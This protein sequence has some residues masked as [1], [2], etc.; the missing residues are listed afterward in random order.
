MSHFYGSLHL[1]KPVW[2]LVL[3]P[4][5]LRNASISRA[6]DK[7][8]GYK[9]HTCKPLT[10]WK[11]YSC[12]TP[13]HT[14]CGCDFRMFLNTARLLIQHNLTATEGRMKRQD[15]FTDLHSFSTVDWKDAYCQAIP[16][17]GDLHPHRP[18]DEGQSLP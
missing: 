10:Q 18:R 8:V 4:I 3:Y 6:S 15:Q 11:L 16:S 12:Q 5:S 13:S 9:L 7:V 1:D 17:E 2:E 14:T